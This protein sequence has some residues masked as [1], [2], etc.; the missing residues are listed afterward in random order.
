MET[1][2]PSRHMDRPMLTIVKIVRRRFRQE[3]LSTNGKYRNICF[4]LFYATRFVHELFMREALD[5]ARR[6][7]AAG[8][9]PIGAVVVVNGVITG[10]GANSPVAR[11]DPT[12]HAEI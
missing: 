10:R 2:T 5:L 6:A 11:N 4:Y 1:I 8:E 3:F 9:V 12:A 7:G